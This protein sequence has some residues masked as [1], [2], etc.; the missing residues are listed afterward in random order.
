[1]SLM[2]ALVGF[3]GFLFTVMAPSGLESL[4]LQGHDLHPSVTTR[5]FDER[6]LRHVREGVVLTNPEYSTEPA[7]VEAI[8]R[9]GSQGRLR[10]DG[11]RA[12][13]FAMYQGEKDLGFYGLEAESVEEADSRETALRD[14]WSHNVGL[15]RAQIHRSDL[16]IVVVWTDG[17]SAE[18]WEAVNAEVTRRLAAP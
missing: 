15:N 8:A 14:I 12:A 6:A 3:L 1:M 17:V 9:S 13:L 2:T 16:A 7:F 18:V 4:I 11:M 5:E 10:G